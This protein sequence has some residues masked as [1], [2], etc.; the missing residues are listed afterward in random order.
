[1][2][3]F[4][5]QKMKDIIGFARFMAYDNTDF[6]IVNKA[7]KVAIANKIKELGIP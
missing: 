6:T 5:D 3:N 7:N 1:M 2:E 4:D